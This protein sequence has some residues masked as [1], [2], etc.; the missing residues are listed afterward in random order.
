LNVDR[1]IGGQDP[2]QQNHNH[3]GLYKDRVELIAIDAAG[4]SRSIRRQNDREETA[5]AADGFS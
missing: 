3:G 1:E 5:E 2:K 4:G